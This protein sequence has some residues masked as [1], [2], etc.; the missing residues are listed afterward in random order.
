MLF[1]NLPTKFFNGVWVRIASMGHS[2]ASSS[3]MQTL[4]F[5]TSRNLHQF[6]FHGFLGGLWYTGLLA[7]VVYSDGHGDRWP[8]FVSWYIKWKCIIFQVYGCLHCCPS[9]GYLFFEEW[10]ALKYCHYEV[11]SITGQ[12]MRMRKVKHSSV[13]E[14]LW[15]NVCRGLFSTLYNSTKALPTCGERFRLFEASLYDH[16][17]PL[18]TMNGY[19]AQS[20]VTFSCSLTFHSSFYNTVLF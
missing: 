10:T 16:L 17:G 5:S 2:G 20:I 3:S 14:S 8:S 1:K 11:G 15:G 18:L 9:T 4:K 12:Y 7:C 6:V 13:G 19:H